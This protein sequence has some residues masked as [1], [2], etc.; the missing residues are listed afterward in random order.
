MD[1]LSLNSD[2]TDR[3]KYPNSQLLLALMIVP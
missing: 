2:F 3:E 1:E